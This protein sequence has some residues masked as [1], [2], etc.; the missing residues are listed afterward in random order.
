M[1]HF[2]MHRLNE[3]GSSLTMHAV[4][5]PLVKNFSLGTL[6]ILCFVEED[7][8]EVLLQKFDNK[9]SIIAVACMYIAKQLHDKRSCLVG[10]VAGII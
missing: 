4:M 10:R 7:E 1:W 6:A 8:S 2:V 3:H 9:Q 5:Q